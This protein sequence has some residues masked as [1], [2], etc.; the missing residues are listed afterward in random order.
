LKKSYW[1]FAFGAALAC[2]AP[3]ALGGIDRAIDFSSEAS[4]GRQLAHEGVSHRVGFVPNAGSDGGWAYGYAI[5]KEWSEELPEWPSVDLKSDVADWSKY[6][7]L[8]IDVVNDAPG[9]DALGLLIAAPTGRV[10]NGLAA[11][12]LYLPDHDYRRWTVPLDNW[13]ATMDAHA[14]GRIHFYSTRPVSANALLSGFY[15]LKPGEEPPP[16]AERFLREKVEPAREKG[17]LAAEARH[18]R[19]VDDFAAKCRAAGQDGKDA[20]FGRASSMVHVRPRADIDAHVKPADAFALSV[21]RGEYA[22]VQAVVMPNGR[23]LEDVRIEVGELT[24]EDQGFLDWFRPSPVL[25]PSSFKTA[26]VGYVRTENPPPYGIGVNV[27]TNLPGGYFRTKRL[28]GTGWWADPILDWLDRAT[29]SGDDVQSFWVRF[30]CPETARAGVYRGVLSVVWKGGRREFPLSVRVYGFSMPKTSSLPL[31]LTFMPASNMHRES[32]ENARAAQAVR[33]DPESPINVWKR[34]AAEWTDFLSE[35][36]VTV[37][38]LYHGG[39]RV[40]WEA[41]LRQKEQGRLGIFNLGY[42]NYPKDLTEEGRR[43]WLKNTRAKLD[44]PYAKAKELG[45]LDRAYLYGCDEVL[46]QYFDNVRWAVEELKKAYPG[47]PLMTT[48]VDEKLGVGT[49]L[50]GIDWLT[51][52]TTRIVTRVGP[53]QVARSRAA[54]HKVWWYVACNQR[55]PYANFF[56]EGPPLEARVLMGAQ[57]IKWRP[58]GFLYYYLSMW[59]GRRPISGTSTFT[60]WDPRSYT[61]YHG[62]GSLFCCGPD[63]IP[64]ATIRIENFRDGIEDYEYARL[65]E[66]AT[67]RTCEVPPEVCR[68][69]AQFTDDPEVIERWRASMAEAIEKSL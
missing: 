15:L 54:G 10:Q 12:R 1:K 2:L 27:S 59:N 47:V 40:N 56:V 3:A 26:P 39:N 8:V 43:N 16:V 53:E 45:L 23:D 50:S 36:F 21:A 29:V 33:T 4:R 5:T 44:A 11:R 30:R 66:R 35:Y 42:W 68:D 49:P 7:R 55:A 19:A 58:D 6:D 60:D 31:A 64:C 46:E 34:H 18:Q 14:V 9:G 63:G 24:R 65:Y 37:D 20:W 57:A 28:A 13:P 17:R 67:G 52:T 69:I 38:S 25:S 61:N 62:D 51:L 32:A 41:L 48:A 22:S